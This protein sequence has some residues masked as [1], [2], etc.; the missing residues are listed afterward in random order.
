[1][2]QEQQSVFLM[3]YSNS[4]QSAVQREV[5]GI[6]L[7]SCGTAKYEEATQSKTGLGG[8][9]QSGG[10]GHDKDCETRLVTV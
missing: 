10:T 5:H 7:S 3:L 4:C 8:G 2:E 9:S 1:M 6:F